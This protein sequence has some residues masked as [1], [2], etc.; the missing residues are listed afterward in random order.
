MPPPRREDQL[1]HRNVTKLE[2]FLRSCGIKPATLARESGY[3]RQRLLQ[4][5][6]GRIAAEPECAVAIACAL[7]RL[8]GECIVLTDVFGS[9]VLLATIR[10]RRQILRDCHPMDRRS[11]RSLFTPRNKEIAA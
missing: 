4:I 8:T 3:S 1:P 2:V 7:R 10:E 6:S 5:R 9:D 11:I